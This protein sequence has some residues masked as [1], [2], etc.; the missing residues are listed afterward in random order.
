MRCR[1]H[2]LCV[3]PAQ[4]RTVS[5]PAAVALHRQ[6]APD[7]LVAYADAVAALPISPNGRRN[8]SGSSARRLRML[9]VRGDWRR[10]TDSS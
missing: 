1:D 5:V 10:R 6:G 2:A 8:R 9:H 7:L 3:G 4:A